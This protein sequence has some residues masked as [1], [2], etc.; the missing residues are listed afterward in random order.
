MHTFCIIVQML[1]IEILYCF[2]F[3]L[4]LLSFLD[5]FFQLQLYLT[6]FEHISWFYR[7]AVTGFDYFP[8]F[9]G[10]RVSHVLDGDLLEGVKSYFVK[11]LFGFEVFRSDK[12]ILWYEFDGF[13][14][15]DNEGRRVDELVFEFESACLKVE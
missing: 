15:I 8:E 3:V 13:S 5:Y 4:V 6:D 2:L 1:L 11:C 7:L 14:L 9:P 12:F 10:L